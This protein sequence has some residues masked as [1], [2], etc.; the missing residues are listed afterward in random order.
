M[1]STW[2]RYCYGVLLLGAATAMVTNPV[3]HAFSHRHFDNHSDV[4]EGIPDAQWSEQNLCPYCDA[5]TH[6]VEVA[7]TSYPLAQ[8]VWLWDITR[9]EATYPD[10]RLHLSPCMRAPP[11]IA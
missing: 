7:P 6:F 10:L 4:A 5:V 11:F 8:L 3:W 1:N 2:I 9:P